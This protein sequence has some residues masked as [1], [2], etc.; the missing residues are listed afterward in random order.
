VLGL[1][2]DSV[3]REGVAARLCCQFG[4]SRV[5]QLGMGPMKSVVSQYIKTHDDGA[6]APAVLPLF[7]L[8]TPVSAAAVPA[9]HLGDSAI[10]EACHLEG[11]ALERLA[12][13]APLTELHQGLL[14]DPVRMSLFYVCVLHT[15]YISCSRHTNTFN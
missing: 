5:E 11:L 13:V 12:A 15:L 8:C 6:A 14:W 9:G 4:I 3:L 7:G 1:L 10:D 2:S